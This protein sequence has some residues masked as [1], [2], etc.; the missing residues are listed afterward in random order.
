MIDFEPL[1]P[2]SMSRARHT[3]ST[4]SVISPNGG[5]G[6]AQSICLLVAVS[7]SHTDTS[8][9]PDTAEM[10]EGGSVGWGLRW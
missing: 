10:R 1:E 3:T 2:Q 9:F 5:A 6:L 8:L 4:L 7:I